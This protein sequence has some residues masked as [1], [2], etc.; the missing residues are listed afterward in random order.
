MGKV[1]DSQ[2]LQ[3]S[4]SHNAQIKRKGN[5]SLVSSYI[6][7]NGEFVSA[8]KRYVWPSFMEESNSRIV[9]KRIWGR[10]I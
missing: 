9:T 6:K 1:W 10:D 7:S 8:K 5:I 3:D 4:V 2:Y